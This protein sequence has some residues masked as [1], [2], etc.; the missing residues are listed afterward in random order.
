MPRLTADNLAKWYGRRVLFGSLSFTLEGGTSLAVT[1]ANGSGKSTLIKMLAGV[2]R[3]SHG[4]V[5]LEVEGTT[6]DDQE[7]PLRVGLVAPYMNMYEGFTA[8]ENLEFIARA[9]RL[10]GAGQRIQAVLEEVDLPGRADDFVATFSSG[11]LQRVR[12]A[13]ALLASPPLLLLDEPGTNLDRRGQKMVER[14][15]RRQQERGQLLVVA[16]NDAA[17]AAR[18]DRQLSVEDF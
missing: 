3:P 11:M 17:E 7:R 14:I 8:R 4:Q 9:R 10:E 16:T 6:V 15:E 1:G 12:F 18:Q 5:E 2:L 13:A